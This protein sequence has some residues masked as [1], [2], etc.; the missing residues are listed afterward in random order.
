MA[1]LKNMVIFR[2]E[3]ADKP[4]PI[5]SYGFAKYSAY[6]YYINQKEKLKFCS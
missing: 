1:V 4:K 5:T 3:G 6:K 2:Y